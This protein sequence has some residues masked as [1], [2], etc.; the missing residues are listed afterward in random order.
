MKTT[1]TFDAPRMLTYN[2]FDE[3]GAITD[4]NTYHKSDLDAWSDL[5]LNF[6]G[7][8]DNEKYEIYIDWYNQNCTK[9]GQVL[10]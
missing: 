5:G 9:L 6:W 2:E 10:A 1:Q 7:C 4:F 3:M 8:D